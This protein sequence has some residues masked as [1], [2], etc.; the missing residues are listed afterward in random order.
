MCIKYVE[1]PK[2]NRK[3]ISNRL[4]L[5]HRCFLFL[6]QEFNLKISFYLLLSVAE[7]EIFH[8]FTKLPNGSFNI[9][10]TDF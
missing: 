2:P 4:F 8:Q 7:Q 5:Y 3:C 9:E 1:M 10:Q 6:C